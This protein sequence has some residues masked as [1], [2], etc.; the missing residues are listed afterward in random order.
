MIHKKNKVIISVTPD[1]DIL[2]IKECT[3]NGETT[4][5]LATFLSYDKMFTPNTNKSSIA[6][7]LALYLEE[8]LDRLLANEVVTIKITTHKKSY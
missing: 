6:T 3:R 7:H 1:Y 2:F 8:K 4:V 5:R